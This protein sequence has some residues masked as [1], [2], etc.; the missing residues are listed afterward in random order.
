MS[1]GRHLQ[2]HTGE[3]N[4]TMRAQRFSGSRPGT[5]QLSEVKAIQPL[6]GDSGK[7]KA[8][9]SPFF[10]HCSCFC[11]TLVS[12]HLKSSSKSCPLNQACSSPLLPHFPLY[13]SQLSNK[14]LSFLLEWTF[15]KRV[16][17][18]VQLCSWYLSPWFFTATT[19]GPEAGADSVPCRRG[20]EPVKEK[21][22]RG[23]GASNT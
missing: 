20:R 12:T 21:Y 13:P 1:Q 9:K 2:E 6:H 22:F 15:I 19:H 16:V 5:V 14:K 3:P 18:L 7:V 4:V 17:H 10:S 23:R 11:F 8:L